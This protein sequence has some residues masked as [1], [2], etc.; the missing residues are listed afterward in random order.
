MSHASR[1]SAA[2]LACAASL[3]FAAPAS[4]QEPPRAVVSIYR[5]APG[6][7]LDFLKWMAARE[8]VAREAGIPA[9]QWYAHISGDSWDFLV[10]GP[11]LDDAASDK[12]DALERK[13]GL[14]VGPAASL[15][16]REVMAW[17]TDTLAAGPMTA[18][19]LIDAAGKP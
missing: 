9:Q 7:Q 4:A 14:K 3:S 5:P 8:A 12:V 10:I 16:F 13:R 2:V 18:A 11:D 17:H 15:E 6:K 19:Q 1:L